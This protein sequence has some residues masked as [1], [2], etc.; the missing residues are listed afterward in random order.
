MP[1]LNLGRPGGAGDAATRAGDGAWAPPR[2]KPRRQG[3]QR[4]G[5]VCAG[6]VR[7]L[8]RVVGGRALMAGAAG[9]A[10]RAVGSVWPAP[11]H[12]R[13]ARPALPTAATRPAA[14]QGV[15]GPV[16]ARTTAPTAAHAAPAEPRRPPIAAALP[17]RAAVGAILGVVV[18]VV[19]PK[20]PATA[21]PR[22]FDAYIRKRS[23]APVDAYLPA[24][25]AARAQLE[26]VEPL[27]GEGGGGAERVGAPFSQRSH[28]FATPTPL[29]SPLSADDPREARIL[30]R[31]GAFEGLRDNVR[32]VGE[33]AAA[34]DNAAAAAAPAAFFGAVQELDFELFAAVREARA[35]DA[36]LT[37]GKAAAAVAALDALLAA[38]PPDAL[39]AASKI[40]A[41]AGVPVV[42]AGGDPARVPAAVEAVVPVVPK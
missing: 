24:V 18:T 12:R 33:F 31:S 35:P 21:A 41:A 36:G 8:G 20:P 9:V 6:S 16:P 39:E 7:A 22:G 10:R 2:R 15:P 4:A 19:A 32:A 30:L 42:G 23:L 3:A 26:A 34:A 38:A 11:P 28:P 40:A 25:L 1:G 14:M 13:A 37:R 29:L 27:L 17:R 5:G